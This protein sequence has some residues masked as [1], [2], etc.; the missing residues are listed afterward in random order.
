M[1]FQFYKN[2]N[3][4]YEPVFLIGSKNNGIELSKSDACFSLF[5][6]TFQI[7]F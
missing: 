6:Y 7:I 1:K 2:I 3:T 4:D 5:G